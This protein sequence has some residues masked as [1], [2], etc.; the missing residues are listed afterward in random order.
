[1]HETHQAFECWVHATIYRS[2]TWY[3]SGFSNKAK[4]VVSFQPTTRESCGSSLIAPSL[5][6]IPCSEAPEMDTDDGVCLYSRVR[7]VIWTFISGTHVEAEMR[8]QTH[9]DRQSDPTPRSSQLAETETRRRLSL[10]S[11]RLSPALGAL[12]LQRL[13]ADHQLTW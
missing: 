13:A 12:G 8:R 7:T 6:T 5:V 3:K 10:R 1:M 2:A 9:L 4:A 11:S